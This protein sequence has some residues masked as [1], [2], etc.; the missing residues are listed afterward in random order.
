MDERP[1]ETLNRPDSALEL[2][3]RPS[4]FSD[5]TGQDKIKERLEIAVAA[6]K[7]RGDVLDHFLL[8][9]PPGL[10]K[11]T[12]AGIIAKSMGANLKSTSDPKK[13]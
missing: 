11:T 4:L 1:L 3:L 5:F 8:N 13:P 2:T 10:G 7:Q 6:A 9:G 12:L